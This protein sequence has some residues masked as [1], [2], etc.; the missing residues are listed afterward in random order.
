MSFN[1]DDLI[2]DTKKCIDLVGEKT[3]SAFEYS[4]NQVERIRLKGKFRDKLGELGKLCYEMHKTGTDHTGSMK[5][6]MIELEDLEQQIKDAEE[7]VGTPVVCELCGTKNNSSNTYCTKC[8]SV[9]SR[10]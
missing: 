5:R 9:L 1:I 8:G 6:M 10:S 2:Y 3:G 4:K 7:A